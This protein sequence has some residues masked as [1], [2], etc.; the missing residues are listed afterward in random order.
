MLLGD[1]KN[2]IDGYEK[3]TQTFIRCLYFTS[4][5]CENHNTKH[6]ITADKSVSDAVST[7]IVDEKKQINAT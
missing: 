6:Q 5:I 1:L 7:F 2:T 4:S 3:V